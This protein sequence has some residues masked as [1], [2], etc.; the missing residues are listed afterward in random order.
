[1]T[2]TTK[3]QQ[4][5]AERA[6]LEYV[7]AGGEDVATMAKIVMEAYGVDD[8]I[9]VEADTVDLFLA[10]FGLP[11]SVCKG[12]VSC[13]HKPDASYKPA[14]NQEARPYLVAARGNRATRDR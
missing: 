14:L 8:P 10:L 6:L 1:M 11:L 12:A 4:D 9:Q 7:D 13:L 3:R 5:E 2:G